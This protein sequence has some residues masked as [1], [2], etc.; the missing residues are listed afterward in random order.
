[1]RPTC[2]PAGRRDP[3]AELTVAELVNKFLT[4][5]RADVMAGEL[6]AR[7]WYEYHRTCETLIEVFGRTRTVTDLKPADF[8]RL[9]SSASERL[10]VFALAKHVQMVRTVFKFAYDNAM[11]A[12][13]IRS[14][15]A[16]E[17]FG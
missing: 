9:R 5:C 10:G 14:V 16:G 2:K 7:Q 6:S 12:A 8:G 17:G 1:M 13:P 15:S 3:T 4:A 11:I